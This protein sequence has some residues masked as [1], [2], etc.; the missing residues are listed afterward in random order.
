MSAPEPT[1]GRA[2]E[3]RPRDD[4][5][6]GKRLGK[7]LGALLGDY[8]GEQAAAEV[9]GHATQEQ[10]EA[11]R[12]RIADV[13]PNAYQ[14]RREF[15]E[16]E[17]A[18]LAAS[19]EANGLL[20][21]I[22]VRPVD[23]PGA[24]RWE[25]VAGERRWRAATRLGWTDIPAVVRDVDDRTMLVLALVENIQRAQL[26]AL[27]EAQAYER[28]GQE[29][30]LTQQQIADVV[31][32]DRSTVANAIRLLQLPASVRVL[33][34]ENRLSAGHARALLGAD[35][36]RTIADLA[37]RAVE[38]GWSVREVEAEVQRTRGASRR[39]PRQEKQRDATERQL[40]E[41][42]QRA[43]GTDVRIKRGRGMKG[44]LE[45]PFY[46]AEDFE[47]LFEI[48]AGRSALDVVS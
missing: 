42:L 8:L 41:E 47:R 25:L 26:N 43:L 17:L 34:S 27:E 44:K 20:Q 32:K 16:Q 1:G 28:L 37:R 48:L 14:P 33:L 7:G 4:K 12:I 45:I 13:R 24:T 31:G 18:D 38:Q 46:G 23:G 3:S 36:D 6:S 22:V 2:R 9:T 21:P 10:P 5:R 40:E 39:R 30:S 35:N 11:R 29:F 19:L 15:S